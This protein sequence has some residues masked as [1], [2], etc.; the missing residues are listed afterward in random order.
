MCGS[1]AF[2]VEDKHQTSSLSGLAHDTT[3]FL[4]FFQDCVE[5]RFVASCFG[6]F[7]AERISDVGRKVKSPA[8][9]EKLGCGGILAIFLG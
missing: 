4:S 9:Q 1:C 3:S 7:L 5:E 2:R 6:W 8:V